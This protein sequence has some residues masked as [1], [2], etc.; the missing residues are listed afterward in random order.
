MD[1]INLFTL[2]SLEEINLPIKMCGVSP[3]IKAIMKKNRS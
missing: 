1:T 3:K 2:N